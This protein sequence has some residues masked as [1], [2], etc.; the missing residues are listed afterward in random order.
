MARIADKMGTPYAPVGAE[1]TDFV[2]RHT[3]QAPREAHSAKVVSGLPQTG[4][5]GAHLLVKAAS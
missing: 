3:Y 4:N 5:T 2:E 1:F